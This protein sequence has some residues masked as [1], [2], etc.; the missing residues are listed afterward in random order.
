MWNGLIKL[1]KQGVSEKSMVKLLKLVI[2]GA[3]NLLR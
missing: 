2:L 1:N 3:V